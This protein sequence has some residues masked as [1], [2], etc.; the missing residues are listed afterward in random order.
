MLKTIQEQQAMLAARIA[1]G[2]IPNN[3][4]PAEVFSPRVPGTPLQLCTAA[5]NAT[6]DF[7]DAGPC[8]RENEELAFAPVWKLSQWLRKREIT[9]VAL[10]KLCLARLRQYNSKLQCVISFTEKTAMQQAKQ[11]DKELDGGKWRGPLH[12]VPWGAKDIIDTAGHKTTW[13]ATAYRERISD[14]NACVVDKLENAGAVLVAKLALGALAYGD[15]WFG[16]TCKNPFDT[17]EGS[18]G[19][20]AGS[21]SAT[22]AGL[23]PFTLGTE[24]YGSIVSP[25]MRCGTT[26]LRPTFGRVA[27][28][29]VMALCWSLDKIGPIC[30]SVLDTAIVLDTINGKDA[31]DPSSVSEPF[32]FDVNQGVQGLRLG[33]DPALLEGP[34]KEFDRAALHAAER[35]GAT[36]VK[37]S[38]PNI[39]NTMLLIPLFVEASA[40]FE[41]LTRSNQDDLLVWQDDESWPNS[42]RQSW[43]IPAIEHMQASRLRR[44]IMQQM[45]E[46]M[47]RDFDAFLT[48]SFSDLLLTTNGTGHPALVLRT[49][50]PGDKPVG[51]TLIGRLF[52]EGTLCRLGMSIESQL[53]VSNARP[54]LT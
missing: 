8:P 6:D 49:G 34:E 32:H 17:S 33:Y 5:G 36:L 22:A 44:E 11:A 3:L 25:C 19:S 39:D 50:M 53:R 9:S 42:F 23:L 54:N 45:H 48:P 27:R 40:A 4:S 2:E 38:V 18:S 21:A 30:R 12:G 46:W 37:T 15:I 51:T 47:N 20:S 52:D 29:G 1:Q 43:L 14:T 31:G 28:T 13:G 35:A 41:E 16:G 7:P 10:T 26:G 24:T